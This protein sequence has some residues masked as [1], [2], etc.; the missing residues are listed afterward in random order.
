MSMSYGAPMT[1]TMSAPMTTTMSAAPMTYSA[2][3]TYAA[4]MQTYAP[5]YGGY[6]TQQPMLTTEAVEKQ[7]LEATTQLT[8]QSTAQEK[9]LK[10]QLAAQL[11]MLDAETARQIELTKTTY[12]QQLD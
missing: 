9:M 4:P 11:A 10:E 12:T 6:P 5:A 3:M 7:R 8:T 1:T 2:P